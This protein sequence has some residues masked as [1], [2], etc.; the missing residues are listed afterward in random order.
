MKFNTFLHHNP[1]KRIISITRYLKEHENSI[2]E[3]C[4]RETNPDE[5]QL[6]QKFHEKQIKFMQNERLIH[7]IVTLFI[8]LFLLLVLGFSMMVTSWIPHL[9]SFILLILACGY[10]IHYF[11]LENAI[12]RWYIY[13]NRIEAK[14]HENQTQHSKDPQ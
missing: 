6:Y 11:K 4:N 8:C 7:L 10:L 3:I 2:K 5:L 9:L 13:S 14:L 1:V 12:Q